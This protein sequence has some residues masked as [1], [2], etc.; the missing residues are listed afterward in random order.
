MRK[1]DTIVDEIHAIRL[2]TYEKIKDMTQDEQ[3]EYFN[4]R[5]EAAAEKYGFKHLLLTQEQAREL[6][7]RNRAK[8]Q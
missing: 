5:G 8:A 3:I 1:P 4:S 6:S 7:V 2:A